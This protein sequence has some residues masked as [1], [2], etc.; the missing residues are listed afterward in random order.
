MDDSMKRKSFK[1][2]AV[3]LHVLDED[4]YPGKLKISIKPAH[5]INFH[6]KF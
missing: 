2:P 6:H 5:L 1:A 4:F 3:K